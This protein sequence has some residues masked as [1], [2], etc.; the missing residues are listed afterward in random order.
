MK[1]IIQHILFGALLVSHLM[2]GVTVLGQ[3]EKPADIS[4]EWSL[5]LTF[6][7]GTAHHTAVIG[8]ENGK[9][10][11]RY[12]GEYLEGPLSGTVEGN[13]VRFTGRLRNEST[14][15]GYRYT[16]TVEGDTMKGTVDMGEYWTADFTAKRNK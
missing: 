15:V 6:V 14:G 12:K 7:L 1:P 10:T 9:L 4:G 13:T 11:G 16:G 8:Q 3:E 2:T 5:T